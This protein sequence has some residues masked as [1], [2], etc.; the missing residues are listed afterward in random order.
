MKKEYNLDKI[1][2]RR[3]SGSIKWDLYGQEILPLWVAD[4][5]FPVL[6]EIQQ[7]I[8]RRI[9]HPFFGYQKPDGEVLD[10]ICDWVYRHHAWQVTP[11]DILLIP[12][13]VSGFNWVASAFV[14]AK[15]AIAFQT[16]V[17]FPFFKVA[18]NQKIN[19]NQIPLENTENGYRIDFD[20]FEEKIKQNTSL[21]LLCSPHNPV[22]RV[23]NKEELEQIGKVCLEH[24]V[25]ICSD[26]IHCDIVYSGYKHNPIASLAPELAQ[27]TITLMAP[28]KTFNVP[29]LQFS[30]AICQN[31]DL[32][33]KLEKAR[34]GLIENPNVLATIAAKA[35][36]QKGENWLA[37]ILNYLDKNRE[38][39]FSYLT[40][41]IPEIEFHKPEGTYLAWLDCANLRL[42]RSP[43]RFFLEHAKVAL[44]D[45]KQFSDSASHFV[46]LN[47][48]CPRSMLTQALERMRDAVEYHSLK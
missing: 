21:F 14:N 45:G 25:L 48:A 8:R 19:Q 47:F 22:G 40:D 39:L 38:F 7:A 24:D 5:D 36:Y 33:E 15:E 4:M 2:D 29:G 28:S 42:K 9:S 6:E 34:R 41:N 43:F 17:Y 30:F 46:R 10:A 11:D 44:N 16:P 27:N 12:G 20:L 32:R 1:I 37:E 23:F 35:A 31:K 18:E 3:N 13:V 26:E